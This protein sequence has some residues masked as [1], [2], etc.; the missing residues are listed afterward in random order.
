MGWILAPKGF[1]FKKCVVWSF[2]VRGDTHSLTISILSQKAL[3][4]LKVPLREFL[5]ILTVLKA[6]V[7]MCF[8]YTLRTVV[9]IP[10]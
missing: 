3:T 6:H 8:V 4:E 5:P 1:G 9:V 2:R 7:G 10:Q